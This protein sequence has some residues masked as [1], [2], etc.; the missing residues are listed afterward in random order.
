MGLLTL[1]AVGCGSEKSV[2]V[3]T[4][5]LPIHLSN[6]QNSLNLALVA[7]PSHYKMTLSGC[8]SG[9]SENTS[10]AVIKVYSGDHN[11]RLKLDSFVYNASTYVPKAGAG[12]KT[13]AVNDTAIFVNQA[14]AKDLLYLKVSS[15]I[16]SPVRSTDSIHYELIAPPQSSTPSAPIVIPKAFGS[17]F[18]ALGNNNS[19]AMDFEG[20]GPGGAG[21]FQ[22]NIYCKVMMQNNGT[23]CSQGGAEAGTMLLSKLSYK[24]VS[25]S[26]NAGNSSVADGYQLTSTDIANIFASPG[27]TVSLPADQLSDGNQGFRTSPINIGL[28]LDTHPKMVLILNDTATKAFTYFSIQLT[29][30]SN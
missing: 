2:H 5:T 30:I 19:P 8:R 23:V 22:F 10:S 6:A 12:F 7:A 1:L 28:P 4:A 20:I 24:L 14:N 16:S 15:Q 3:I 29:L 17:Q 26:F 21:I 27:N 18:F 25:D 11:C 13:W 9:L